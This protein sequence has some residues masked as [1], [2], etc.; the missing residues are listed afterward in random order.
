MNSK[1]CSMTAF[2]KYSAE[3][4]SGIFTWEIR[5]VNHRYLDCN[6][7]LPE[8]LSPLEIALRETL[9]KFLK[10]GRIECTLKYQATQA[11]LSLT[12]DG[13]LVDQLIAN[14]NLISEK[15]Q[16]PIVVDPMTILAWPN[17]LRIPEVNSSA[18]NELVLSSFQNV[19]RDLISNRER[20]GQA[21]KTAI[22]SMLTVIEKELLKIHDRLPQALNMARQKL[23]NRF[24]ELKADLD[25]V[26]LEQEMIIFSQKI[27]ITEELDRLAIHIEEFHRALNQGGEVGKRLDFLSQELNR[28]INTLTAKS[29]ETKIV[30]IALEIKV[31]LEQIREQVQNLE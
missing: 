21:L 31:L 10:R 12:I 27:D 26:R 15:F 16:K 9:R 22:E 6:M 2:A 23:S 18:V 3:D 11:Q 30:Q 4:A 24:T 13:N 28:E 1:V 25:P 5:A 17:V 8:F 20:E 7:R 14:I 19:L 29:V